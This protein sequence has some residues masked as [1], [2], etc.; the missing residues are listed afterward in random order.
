M[1]YTHSLTEDQ[2]DDIMYNY[3]MQDSEISSIGIMDYIRKVYHAEYYPF[4]KE[5]VFHD[6]K[7]YNWFILKYE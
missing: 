5:L 7:Y 3:A 6:E 1:K 4:R 2:I